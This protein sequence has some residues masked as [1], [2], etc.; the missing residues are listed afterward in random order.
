[1]KLDLLHTFAWDEMNEALDKELGARLGA[2]GTHRI[3][4][5]L[6]QAV[7]EIV[8]GTALF[9]SHR[10]YYG[11]LSGE[12]W[13]FDSIVPNLLKDG[14]QSQSAPASSLEDLKAW[15]ST[16]SKETGFVLWSE[17]HPVLATYQAREEL[18][19]ALNAQRIIS[20]RVSHA[21]FLTRTQE[22]RPYSVRI[23]SLAPDLALAQVGSRFKSPALFAHRQYWDSKNLLGRVMEIL[24]ENKEDQ[25]LVENFEKQFEGSMDQGGFCRL[26]IM[27]P[28]IYD[29]AL[30]FHPE[31]SSEFVA[32]SLA[33][34][35]G[36]QIRPPGFENQIEIINRCRW[37]PAPGFS[38]WWEPRPREAVLAGLLILSLDQISKPD[39]FRMLK[40]AAEQGELNF[41]PSP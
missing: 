4:Q 3:Y 29:R 33:A 23:C 12:T 10:K 20:I 34:K 5:G 17:D 37:Q 36:H 39:I 40:E 2:G 38:S 30:I 9:Y 21:S 28:R 7:F 18:D 19:L 16:L 11:L 31:I 14:F 22:I 32:Q 27:G 24:K 15:V 1:M 6:S 35:Q 8:M 25:T 26:P 13:A 41:E